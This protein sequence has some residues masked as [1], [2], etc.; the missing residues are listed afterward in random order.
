MYIYPLYSEVKC[1]CFWLECR[2]GIPNTCVGGGGVGNVVKREKM[3]EKDKWRREGGVGEKGK[4]MRGKWKSR[5]SLRK[6]RG[7]Y[8]DRKDTKQAKH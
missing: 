5:D 6:G 1:S 8:G 2:S 3:G 4:R 7:R